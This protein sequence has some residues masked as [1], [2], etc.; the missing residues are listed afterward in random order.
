MESDSIQI[1]YLLFLILLL[2]ILSL[3]FPLYS[4]IFYLSIIFIIVMVILQKYYEIQK[5]KRDQYVERQ[6]KEMEDDLFG[7]LHLV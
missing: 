5:E 3:Q 1:Y 6:Q 7:I 4:A 2:I